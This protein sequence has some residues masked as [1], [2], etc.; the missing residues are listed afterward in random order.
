MGLIGRSKSVQA[1]ESDALTQHE[2]S[3]LLKTLSQCKFEGKDVLL[4][5]G[6][7]EKLSASLEEK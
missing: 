6:I 3:F 2:I 1:N 7:V 5:S 4:L